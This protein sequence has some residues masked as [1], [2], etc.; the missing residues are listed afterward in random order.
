MIFHS[1][2]NECVQGL[3]GC[4]H[5]CTNIAGSYFC[6]CADGYELESDNHTCTGNDYN[7]LVTKSVVYSEC[8][9]PYSFSAQYLYDKISVKPNWAL[10]MY[11]I[12]CM[13]WQNFA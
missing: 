8:N 6:T 1:D 10:S 12:I 7:Q 2:I 9:K 11:V 4:D 5:N 3:A 13:Y